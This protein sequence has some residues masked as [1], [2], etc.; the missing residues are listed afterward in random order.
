MVKKKDKRT[1][2]DLLCKTSHRKP[3]IEPHEPHY[4]PEMNFRCCKQFQN[5]IEKSWKQETK[6]LP[7]THIHDRS[8][9]WKAQTFQLKMAGLI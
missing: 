1:N 9:S 2:N 6:S 5:L 7:L 8:L 4:K 3:Q